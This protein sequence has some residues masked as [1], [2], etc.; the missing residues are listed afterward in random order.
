MKI[1]FITSECVPFVKTGGLA[2]VSGSLPHSLSELGNELRVFLPLYDL[3]D[4]NKYYLTPVEILSGN[5]INLNGLK[6]RFDVYS[7]LYNE[8]EYY[9]VDCPFYFGRGAVYTTDDDEDERFIFFQHAV[10]KILQDLKWGPDVFHCNDWQSALVPA[11]LKLVYAWDNLF[12]KSR[13]LLS[14]HNIGYQGMFKPD[15]VLKAGFGESSFVLGGPFEF[16]GFV[17]FLKAGIYYADFV[18]TVSPSYAKEIQ[19]PEFGSGLEGVL[20]ARGDKV[21]GILNG[22]D[23][24]E[25]NPSSDRLISRNYTYETLSGKEDNKRNLLSEAG[26]EYNPDIP[27]FGVVSRLAWQKGMELIAELIKKRHDGK[28]QIVILGKGEKK[29]EDYF[30][31][32]SAEHNKIIKSFIGYDNKLAHRITAGADFFLMPSRYEPCGLNQMY[33][34]NY[35]TVPVVRKVGGLSDTVIDINE[36]ENGNGFTFTEFD[37]ARFEKCFDSALSLYKDK[38]ALRKAIY[39]GMNADFSWEKSAKEY[40]GLYEQLLNIK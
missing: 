8:T 22:I 38:K 29:Y 7:C 16:N 27:L 36:N 20:K 13:T 33:S 2:D 32:A 37:F 9:F 10:I 11:L 14:V 34:L 1:C 30:K 21:F 25:W 15:S 19:T 35:G 3:I 24:K 17:N 28:F 23:T 40:A 6:N 39:N 5:E 31:S 18:S 4:R 26:I 12:E